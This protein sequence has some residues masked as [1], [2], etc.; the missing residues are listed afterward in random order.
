MYKLGLALKVGNRNFEFVDIKGQ[1]GFGYFTFKNEVTHQ[2]FKY[3]DTTRM[4]VK[5]TQREALKLRYEEPEKN[6]G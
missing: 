3:L 5:T 6:C 2:V 1:D 4:D